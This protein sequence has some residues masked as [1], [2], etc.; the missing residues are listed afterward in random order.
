MRDSSQFKLISM[1]T[2]AEN[3]LRTTTEVEVTLI[4]AHPF[5]DGE[6]VSGSIDESIDGMSPRGDAQ[7]FKVKTSNTILAKWKGDGSN[8][9]SAPDVRRGDQ[10]EVWQYGDT[11][12]FFWSAFTQPGKNVRRRETVVNAFSNTVNEDDTELNESNA[13]I[14]EI[15]THEKTITIKT[16]KNDGEPFAYTLQVNAKEGVVVVADDIG[17]YFQ[18]SSD[19]Q[20]IELETSSGGH[21]EVNKKDVNINCEN[22]NLNATKAIT[23][24]A[25]NADVQIPETKWKGN[26]GIMGNMAA[27]G[28]GGGGGTYT[29]NGNVVTTGNITNNGKNIGDSHTH[30]GVQGGPSSTSG[31]N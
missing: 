14:Q 19:L 22:F 27:A 23:M 11:D 20:L 1:G 4:E 26:L 31:V 15:N 21:F 5:I 3:K 12:E 9:I 29:F 8:R 28:G 18:I 24:K 30:G 16:N 25:K 10:V 17:N 13:W 2:V 7:S 6:L